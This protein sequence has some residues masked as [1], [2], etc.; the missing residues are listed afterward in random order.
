MLR[1]ERDR[2]G[3]V[4]LTLERPEA[5]NA[6]SA[7]LVAALSAA[8]ERLAADPGV[9]IV[10]LSGAG[11]AFCGGAD[12]GDMRAA[13]QASVAANEADAG[14]FSRMLELLEILPQPTVA[15]INGAA[16]G[17]GVG[18][19]AACDIALAADHAR[20]ALSEVRLG[21]LPAMISPYVL[22]A[23]GPR[24]ARRWSLTG[25][26]MD[27]A[28]ALRIG[29]V[30]ETAPAAELPARVAAL[31]DELLAGGPRA[32]TEIKRLLTAG[33]GR[34]EASDRARNANNARWL[35]RLRASA[36]GRE[37]LAA[38]LEKRRPDWIPDA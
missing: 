17:G 24:Q 33:C 11:S 15:I 30:H 3:V 36:E 37:G 20:I 21:I 31:V 35:A 6:L 14:R 8:L 38:F 9:R 23:I 18:L 4:T 16:F 26:A 1:E 29:L 32:Q 5:R 22:R 7:A 27:A 10:L 13:A 19:L 25:A 2:R 34:D 28:T 12:I